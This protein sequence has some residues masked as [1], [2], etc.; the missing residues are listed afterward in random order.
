ML[1][2]FLNHI[3]KHDLCQPDD[4]ILLAVSGGVDSVVMLHLFKE[5]GFTIGVAHCNFQ[6]RGKE[7]DADEAF[8]RQLTQQLNIPFF[9][10]R[11]DTDT[12]AWEKGISTQMAAR[13]L[14]YNWFNSLLTEYGYK[15]LAT[16]HHFDDTLETI[17]LNLTRGSSLEGLS[18]IPVRNGKV[19]RPLLFAT[20][21][22]VEKFATDHDILWRTDQ[23]N[24]TD[25]YQRNFIRHQ[26]V[27][28]LRELNPSLEN[29]LHA[30]LEKLQS[31][32]EL[33]HTFVQDWKQQYLSENH[34]RTVIEKKGFEE[35]KH[36][37]HLLWR[38][39][40]DKGFNVEQCV[41]IIRA[42][43][44]QSGKQFLSVTHTLLVDRIQLIITPRLN[45]QEDVLISEY[46]Q[47]VQCGPWK[48]F[49]EQSSAGVEVKA[50]PLLA[51][52]DADKLKYPLR[53]R[54]W[55]PGDFFYP[56]GMD[57][58]RKLSDFLIDKKL[59]RADKEAVIVLESNGDIVWV[60]GH[61]IDNRYKITPETRAALIFRAEPFFI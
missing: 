30:G 7:S 8:V 15:H 19:I 61:R 57:H 34:E 14:R 58:K 45:K 31:D 17:L 11:F 48:F 9:S 53:L 16:G 43:H 60:A 40:R 1:E 54:R 3:R 23:S 50:N 5:A 47:E 38:V 52:L 39:V 41:E 26:I 24:L 36:S 20:R 37:A 13:E 32:I 42:L 46:Q 35:L 44:H 56:L 55:R 51:F 29:T 18:G 28:K 21:V 25:D 10:N 22:E 12:F 33:V 27:P 6:L 49:L 4:T 2:Q 59:S